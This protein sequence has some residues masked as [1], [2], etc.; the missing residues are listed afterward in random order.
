MGVGQQDRHDLQVQV[1]IRFGA[2]LFIVIDFKAGGLGC[3]APVADSVILGVVFLVFL[4]RRK[5]LDIG[6]ELLL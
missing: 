1:R 4:V 5:Q 3:L 6:L 2:A